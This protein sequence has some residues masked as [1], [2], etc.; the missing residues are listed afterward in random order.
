MT[1]P[2]FVLEAE[3]AT[4]AATTP[5]TTAAFNILSLDVLVTY[6]M[7]ESNSALTIS[8]SGTALAWTQQQLVAVA[9]FCWVSIWTHV[10]SQSRAAVTVSLAS[11]GAGNFGGDLLLFR[12]SDGVGASSKA[13]AAG[14]APTLNLTTTT[15]N[16]AILVANADFTAGTGS[17]TWRTGAGA[18]TE[19]TFANVAAA[20]TAYGGYHADAGSIGTYA[21]GLTAPS[22]TYSIAAVEIKSTNLAIIN[23]PVRQ[24]L[25]G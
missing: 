23:V 11:G 14:A 24:R 15:P 20:Y 9:G 13:N 25:R 10:V 19:T 21:V 4:Y 17:R 12:G 6:A 3:T 8:N 5:K 2:A 7:V 16:S 22:Q 18:L 1:A